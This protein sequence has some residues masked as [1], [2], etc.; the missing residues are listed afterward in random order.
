MKCPICVANGTKSKVYEGSSFSTLIGSHPFYDEDGVYHDHDP[1]THSDYYSCT[2]GHSFSVK[3][4]N[5]CP[6]TGCEWEPGG[7][8]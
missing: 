3:R 5:K 1:N 2:L 7:E 6:A 4:I 8:G